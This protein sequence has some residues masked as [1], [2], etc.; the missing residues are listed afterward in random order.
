V[1]P[2]IGINDID[3]LDGASKEVLVELIFEPLIIVVDVTDEGC[4]RE[5]EA[6]PVMPVTPI[7]VLDDA[8]D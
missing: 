8:V 2:N 7:T 1:P 6:L 3:D 4:V 5:E